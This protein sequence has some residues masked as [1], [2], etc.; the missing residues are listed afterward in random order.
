MVEGNL[1]GNGFLK[2]AGIFAAILV[3][4]GSGV[5]GYT[6]VKNDTG[7]NKESIIIIH[8]DIKE[9]RKDQTKMLVQMTRALTILED[10]KKDN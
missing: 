8:T 1:N 4:F 6:D 3:I 7:D 5:A 9:L 2:K 10:W